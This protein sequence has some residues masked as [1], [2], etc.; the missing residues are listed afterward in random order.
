M[1]WAFGGRRNWHCV[2]FFS[3]QRMKLSVRHNFPGLVAEYGTT[4]FH[5]VLFL[6]LSFLS[7]LS[8]LSELL[9]QSEG[10][11]FKTEHGVLLIFLVL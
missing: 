7:E 3:G 8:S 4:W 11:Y 10:L 6:A 5:E 1:L 2:I 9:S